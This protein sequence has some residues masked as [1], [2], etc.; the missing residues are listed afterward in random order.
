MSEKVEYYWGTGRRKSSVARVRLSAGSGKIVINGRE[1]E[2]HFQLEQ[3]RREVDEPLKLTKALPRFDIFI[4]VN[5]GGTSGQAGAV[6]LGIARA[7]IKI[8][9]SLEKLLRDNSM[10]TRDPRMKERKKY[11]RKGARKGFQFSKR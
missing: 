1:L 11:G 2:K 8:D 10:L 4:N 9:S 3:D 5:G 7:L 6:K